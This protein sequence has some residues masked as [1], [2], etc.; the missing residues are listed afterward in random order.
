MKF[1]LYHFSDKGPRLDNQ[2]SLEFKASNDLLI[3]CI[4]DGVGGSNCG[5][6]A[7]KE[8][9]S[10][11]TRELAN[12]DFD[13]KVVLEKINKRLKAIQDERAECIGMATTFTG[14][15]IIKKSLK[16][17]HIGDTRLFVLRKNGIKQITEDH[18]E[19]NALLKDGIITRKEAKA[20]PRKHILE[21]AL[22]GN[23]KN[24]DPQFFELDLMARDRI[25]IT[26]DGVHEIIEKSELR[27]LSVKSKSVSSFGD[28]L[29]ESIRSKK[30]TDNYSF[31]IAELNL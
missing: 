23:G 5:D 25:L 21:R 11:F 24:V 19:V 14:Y 27:D 31:I 12:N 8:S 2:D 16:G 1:D 17:I 26:T 20:Y 4:A 29:L 10:E 28:S 18:T 7:A 22:T 3:A 9:V 15:Y 13:L 6:V 30:I